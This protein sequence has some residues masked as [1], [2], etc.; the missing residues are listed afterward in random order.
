MKNKSNS[1]FDQ[2]K[3]KKLILRK[4][5]ISEEIHKKQ[6]FHKKREIITVWIFKNIDEIDFP[7]KNLNF[8]N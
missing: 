7:E 6:A 8:Q 3:K 5:S 1:R 2:Q 4:R